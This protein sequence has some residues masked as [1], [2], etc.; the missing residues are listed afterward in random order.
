MTRLTYIYFIA[1]IGGGPIKIGCSESPPRR[2]ENLM[3]WSPY[4]LEILASA[5]GNLSDE[6]AVHFAFLKH[7]AQREWFR[8][9]PEIYALINE[10]RATGILPEAFKGNINTRGLPHKS[11]GG[12]SWSPETRAKIS[13]LHKA[14]WASI[15]AGR[16][17][18]PEV[19]AFLL[20]TGI[21]PTELSNSAG[22]HSWVAGG[23]LDGHQYAGEYAD[24]I[25]AYIRDHAALQSPQGA[26]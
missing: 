22:V 2:L 21:A 9:V 6:R 8:A 11:P 25:L 24:K 12:A 10:I 17:A 26:A 14:R 5:P 4:P 7:W 1:P 13:A 16:A 20:K 3:A 15:R 18:R 23:I 19:E